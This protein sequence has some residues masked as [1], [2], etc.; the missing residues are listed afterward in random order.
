LS[1]QGAVRGLKGG[2]RPYV[3]LACLLFILLGLVSILHHEMWRDELQH[4]L[5]AR[6]H[7]S[8]P[9]LVRAGLSEKHPQAWLLILFVLARLTTSPLAMQ[10]VHLG[11]AS[12]SAF[13]VLKYAPFRPVQRILLAFGYYLFFE[14]CII[15]RNY[16]L[17]VLFLFLFCAL[18]PRFRR[19]PWLLGLILFLAANTSAHALIVA[20]GFGTALMIE[21]FTQKEMRRQGASYLALLILASG[22]F[23]S[24][25]QQ[26]PNT[27]TE[28]DRIGSVEL[29]HLKFDPTE[30]A[31]VLSFLPRAALPVPKFGLHF[32]NTYI[33]DRLPGS[34]VWE[35][36]L[37]ALIVLSAALLLRKNRTA[38][39][40]Y[41]LSTAGLLAFFY[42]ISRGSTRHHGFLFIAFVCSLWLARS[43]A[44]TERPEPEIDT[45]HRTGEKRLSAVLTSVLL[46]QVLAGA[47]AIGMDWHY[48]F[49]QAKAMADY[50]QRRGL[51]RLPIIGD[52]DFMI[53]PVAG[54]LDRRVFYP[55][56]GDWGSY[57]I[58][59]ARRKIIRPGDILN[60]ARRFCR[61]TNNDCLILLS[62][63]LEK[64][65][66][67]EPGLTKVTETG[68]AIVGTEVYY[69]YIMKNGGWTPGGP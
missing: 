43:T 27:E 18:Y 60:Q 64:T 62:Y 24:I 23:L 13:L 14:Y 42:V 58:W 46:V 1:L 22:I 32:W 35:P 55:Q 19:K 21:V 31:S 47:Y 30:F 65:Y 53:T 67:S 37:A 66:E 49:S 56:Q 68:D 11:L 41:L 15:S 69:L 5:Q 51:A 16:G 63:P 59:K 54:Y 7:S 50:I 26:T 4:W 8:L 12:V 52:V 2:F 57:A 39:I 29:H 45:R 40:G 28:W 48:P 34:R 9:D 17:G 44:K 25:A 10:I 36:A 33:L 38:L 6:E 20:L 3:I 61:M